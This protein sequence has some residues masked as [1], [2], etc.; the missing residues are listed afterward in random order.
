MHD[1]YVLVLYMYMKLWMCVVL[2]YTCCMYAII[3]GGSDRLMPHRGKTVFSVCVH[4]WRMGPVDAGEG[5]N[6]I[7]IY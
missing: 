2:V 1:T 3:Y 5:E 6:D 4:I 7:S